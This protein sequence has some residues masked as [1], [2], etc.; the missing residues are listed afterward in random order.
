MTILEKIESRQAVVGVI[1]LGYVGL[2]LAVAFAEEGFRVIGIDV[3]QERA[4]AI[5]RGE[6]YISDVPSAQLAAVTTSTVE[7]P[8]KSSHASGKSRN[9]ED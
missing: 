9:R 6:S 7:I 4:D 3:N 1:G 5:N 2:P 8:V